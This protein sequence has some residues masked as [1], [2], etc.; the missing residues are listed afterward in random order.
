MNDTVLLVSNV[1]SGPPHR[2]VQHLSER[3]LP[4]GIV[5][6]YSAEAYRTLMA[7]GPGGRRRARLGSMLIYPVRVFVRVLRTRPRCVIATTNPFILPIVLVATRPLHRARVVGLLYDLIPDALQVTHG[8]D[9][10]NPGYRLAAWGNR[11]WIRHA[12]GVVFLGERMAEYTQE[13]Y[14][15][16]RRWEIIGVG[17]DPREFEPEALGD[18]S[19]CSDLERWCQ[20]RVVASYVGNLGLSHDWETLAEAVPRAL[21]RSELCCVVCASGPGAEAL[22]RAWRNLPPDRVRFEPPLPD[23]EWARLLVR[24]AISLVTVREKA[25]QIPI[26]FPSKMFSAMAAGSAIMAVGPP[27]SDPARTVSRYGCGVSVMPGDVE[28]LAQALVGLASDPQRLAIFRGNARRAA[29]E[30]FDLREL[31][32]RWH[33]LLDELCGLTGFKARPMSGYERA[34]RLID[35]VASAAGL[36]A[37]AP[38]LGVVAACIRVTMGSPVFFKQQRAGQGGK[39]FEL[40]KFRTMRHP[41]AGEDGPQHDAARLTRLGRWLRLTSLDELPTLWNVFRGDMSLV[42]PRP[43]S[44]KYLGRYTSWQAR[45]HEVK[46]GI[47][48]WAQINGRNALGWEERFAL[49]VEYVES[50]SLRWDLEILARTVWKVLRAEGISQQG[51]ATMSEFLGGQSGDRHDA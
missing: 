39:T 27:G 46:P 33:Q 5:A 13:T 21:E 7:G 50:C 41:R 14:G 9:P 10:R 43:L 8:V 24:S 45:R 22:R 19:P 3:G 35:V 20:G 51:H 44:V 49:D 40:L 1:D 6:E 23:R 17:A 36:V 28:G 2:L 38:L 32:H 30:D 47:T 15:S 12:D 16:P 34:K 48:G 25:V 18:P 11:Y 31:A 42:G 26:G 4:S 37:L 29:L